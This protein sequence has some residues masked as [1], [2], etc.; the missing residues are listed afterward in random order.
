MKIEIFTGSLNIVVRYYYR[1]KIPFYMMIVSV[2]R[3]ILKPGLIPFFGKKYELER[4]RSLITM[5]DFPFW[6]GIS[7]QNPRYENKEFKF[8]C[9]AKQ[10]GRLKDTL[11]QLGWR[12]NK[13]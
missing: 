8:Y 3:I 13:K 12:L 5:I 10:F 7:I 11:S 2:E 6:H 9:D 1:I 4:A